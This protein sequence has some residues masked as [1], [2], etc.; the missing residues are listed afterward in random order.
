MKK[1]KAYVFG[2]GD[3]KLQPCSD[4][5]YCLTQFSANGADHNAKYSHPCRFAD[6]CR[7]PE[8]NLTHQPHQV[9]QC[10][11]DKNCENLID[12][13]HRSQFHHTGWPYFLIPCYNQGRCTIKTKNHL[14]KYSHG[15]RV[16][17]PTGTQS[18]GS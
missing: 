13:I 6:L 16:F 10:P 2:G 12:P 1:A 4:G 3:S 9:P 17:E 8:A 11:F 14:I 15:E 5:I 18:Q 7:Q